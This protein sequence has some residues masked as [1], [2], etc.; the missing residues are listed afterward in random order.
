MTCLNT[1]IKRSINLLLTY[2]IKFIQPI[3]GIL[4]TSYTN[5]SPCP[6]S[7]TTVKLTGDQGDKFEFKT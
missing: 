1:Q 4:V 6:E 3:N 5:F 2:L 7:V